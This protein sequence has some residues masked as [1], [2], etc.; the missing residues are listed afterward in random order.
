[1]NSASSF[2]NLNSSLPTLDLSSL[3]SSA[4]LPSP[5]PKMLTSLTIV[6]PRL[7]MQH[8]EDARLPE[9]LVSLSLCVHN[10]PLH[11]N[12]FQLLPRA[13]K[14]LRIEQ[15]PSQTHGHF[16]CAPGAAARLM[17]PHLRSL[18]FPQLLILPIDI[19]AFPK[20][21]KEVEILGG[22][23][24]TDLNL[25]ELSRH[26]NSDGY[27]DASMV[28]DVSRD[29]DDD[30]GETKI[31]IG[32][33]SITGFFLHPNDSS[34]SSSLA[35]LDWKS[36]I[37]SSNDGLGKHVKVLR[38][39]AKHR[40]HLPSM[41]SELDLSSFRPP[42]CGFQPQEH[43]RG[44][45]STSSL[46]S[47]HFPILSSLHFSILNM[48]QQG[49]TSLK[50]SISVRL[51]LFTLCDLPPGLTHLSI[52]SCEGISTS[53]AFAWTAFPRGLK[54]IRLWTSTTKPAREPTSDFALDLPPNLEEL[55]TPDIDYHTTAYMN[56]PKT[57]KR[58]CVRGIG[59]DSLSLA[60]E[61]LPNVQLS[62]GCRV[63]LLQ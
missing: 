35:S 8:I 62:Y 63:T 1:M 31:T 48:P 58:L 15:H 57:V 6:S 28:V 20:T 38:W 22:D 36:F 25:L 23:Q 32:S 24:W 55:F 11:S 46:I 18:I 13:L 39:M 3:N 21:L 17:P 44:P 27:A 42:L 19:N 30:D 33:A 50:L 10:G 59:R 40:M 26:F 14:Y 37:K 43:L 45:N 9:T 16:S 52:S 61:S 47:P 5:W 56:I 54:E 29:S 12:P 41:I 2:P 7:S 49:L 60:A 34:S 53:A 4:Q 51:E